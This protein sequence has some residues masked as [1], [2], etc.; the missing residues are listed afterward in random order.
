MYSLETVE[1]INCETNM[2]RAGQQLVCDNCM[3]R[4]D[5]VRKTRYGFGWFL[6]VINKSVFVQPKIISQFRSTSTIERCII[7][8]KATPT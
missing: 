1:V 3:I 5:F 6:G 4:R 7:E 8:P 2:H